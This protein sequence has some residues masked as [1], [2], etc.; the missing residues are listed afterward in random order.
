MGQ[1]DYVFGGINANITDFP[2][3]AL[4]LNL[5][6]GRLLP[7]CGATIL[8]EKYILT[9]AHCIRNFDLRV[10]VGSHKRSEV[11]IYKVKRTF[12]HEKYESNSM[13][14]A[15]IE[16][17]FVLNFNERIQP[18]KLPKSNEFIPHFAIMTL[19]GWG[20]TIDSKSTTENLQVLYIPIVDHKI[21]AKA[22]AD[23]GTNYMSIKD[24]EIC[25][26]YIGINNKNA[27]RGDSGGP[28]T[29]DDD[30]IFGIVSR[31]PRVC[32]QAYLPAVYTNVSY[33]RDWI[34]KKTG[35]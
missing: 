5:T 34:N 23:F 9:A 22:Y 15:I 31:G 10:G 6:Y 18:I 2:Y 8:S 3:Q 29:S 11:Q 35:L 28:L 7:I 14:I 25:A 4:L 12:V 26:G 1:L 19:S 33:F 16:L 21:C 30:I 17:K 32:A 24:W 13:D 27:C 20:E